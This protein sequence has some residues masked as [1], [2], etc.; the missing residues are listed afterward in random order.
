[1]PRPT[2]WAHKVS[3]RVPEFIPFDLSHSLNPQGLEY[4]PH[5]QVNRNIDLGALRLSR[6]PSQ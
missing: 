1:M 4:F 6:A 2:A 5:L 3:K